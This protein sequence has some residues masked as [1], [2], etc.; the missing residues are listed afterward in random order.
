MVEKI[1]EN[2]SPEEIAEEALARLLII[3]EGL[4]HNQDVVDVDAP[5]N[6]DRQSYKDEL[7]Q[8]V[9]LVEKYKDML[10]ESSKKIS[11]NL[12]IRAKIYLSVAK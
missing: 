3:V 7:R 6:D 4:E 9:I 5:I 1:K 8:C 12:L 10:G 11:D 2:N